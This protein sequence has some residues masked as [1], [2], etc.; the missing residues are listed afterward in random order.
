[1]VNRPRRKGTSAETAVANYLRTNGMP[2]AERRALNGSNDKGDI[3]GVPGWVLE[4]KA[5]AAHNYGVWLREAEQERVNA[6][7]EHCAVV[8]KPSGVADAAR[9]RVV[10]TLEQFTALLVEQSDQGIRR[11]IRVPT[12]GSAADKTPPAPAR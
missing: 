8:H 10:L 7:V 11:S 5:S 3:A 2:Q 1:M 9:Y 4:V 6:A 12:G